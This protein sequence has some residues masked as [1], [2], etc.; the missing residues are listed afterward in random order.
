MNV[1]LL[2]RSRN[3]YRAPMPSR[4]EVG[5][6]PFAWRAVGAILVLTVLGAFA[7]LWIVQGRP[8][9][10]GLVEVPLLLLLTTPLLVL[11]SREERRFDLAGLIAVGFAIRMGATYYRYTH[12]RDG[13]TYHNSGVE[14]ARH[15]RNLDFNVDPGGSVPGTGGMKIIAGIVSVITNSN[16]FASFLL[17]AWLGFLACYLFYRALV[18]AM[19]DADHHRYALLIFLWPSLVVWL[20]SLGKDCWMLFTIAIA[21]L[22]AAKVLRRLRGGYFLLVVGLL[23]G[24][25]VRPHVSLLVLIAFSIAHLI[26]RRAKRSGSVTASSVTKIAGLAIL[27][28]L[29]SVLATRT[30]TLLDANDISG[31]VDEQLQGVQARTFEGESSFPPANPTNPVGYAK[32]AVTIL[33]R[34]F[35]TEADGMEGLITAAEAMALFGLFA[36]SI[37]RLWSMLRRLRSDPYITFALCYG[38]MF[39][40]AFGTVANFG[41]LARQRSQLLPFVFVLLAVNVVPR[42][43]REPKEPEPESPRQLG[44]VLATAPVSPLRASP[45]RVAPPPR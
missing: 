1:P 12:A 34:P 26:G 13:L 21:T 4:E 23:L 11:A 7:G 14:L 8:V 25:F 39:V 2:Q 5:G 31:S 35:I 41:I 37:P 20:S 24:S 38:L 15:F 10:V 42:V 19:P 28:V 36:L 40:F 6:T 9:G 32:A 3:A 18:I 27:L 17:F 22:G 29:G 44:G 45:A 43:R 16:A 30:S 33:F